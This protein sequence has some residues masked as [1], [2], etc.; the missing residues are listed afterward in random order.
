MKTAVPRKTTGCE[1]GRPRQFNEDA[2]LAAAASA[3]WGHGYHATSIDDLCAA[4]GL[5]RGSLYAAYGDKRGMF[6]A[7]LDKYAEGRIERL[8]RSLESSEPNREV[9]REALLYYTRTAADLNG[10]RACF[11]TN[12]A[13]ELLPQDQIVA[14]RIQQIF[15]RMAALL[16][17]AV[18]RAQAVGIFKAQQDEQT[19]GN[20]LLCVIQGLRIL[21][22]ACDEKDLI[23]VVDFALRALE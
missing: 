21:S 23:K 1:R 5:L 18:K 16:A 12:T 19:I 9:L 17:T 14:E 22:K 4:T 13:L 15:R 6:L 8:A 10:L 2:V 7:A 20:F 11:I 3:F